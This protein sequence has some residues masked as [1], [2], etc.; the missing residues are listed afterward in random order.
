MG[1]Q[2]AAE[3]LQNRL[4]KHDW[5][6]AVAVGEIND[7]PAIYVYLKYAVKSAELDS[8]KRDGWMGYQVIV[9]RVGTVRP[10]VA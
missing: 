1:I 2:E 3:S 9:E 7:R 6:T 5:L 10:A 4:E 8:L